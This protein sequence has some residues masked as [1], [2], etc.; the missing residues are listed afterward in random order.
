MSLTVFIFGATSRGVVLGVSAVLAF[1]IF[2]SAV[3]P[4]LAPFFALFLP[5]IPYVGSS[6]P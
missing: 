6:F 5:V 4:V 3:L 2:V 1:W